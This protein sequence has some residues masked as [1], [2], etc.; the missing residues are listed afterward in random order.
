MELDEIAGAPLAFDFG[1][2]TGDVNGIGLA[3]DG[4]LGSDLGID[5]GTDLGGRGLV[6]GPFG[7]AEVKGEGG[8]AGGAEME[9]YGFGLGVAGFLLE[10]EAGGLGGPFESGGEVEVDPD[11]RVST[12]GAVAGGT[13]E[14]GVDAVVGGE[15]GEGSGAA[16]PAVDGVDAAGGVAVIGVVEGVAVALHGSRAE[17]GVEHD[18]LHAVAVVAVAGG[19][20]EITGY[21]HVGIG[22]AGGLEGV[23]GLGEAG[24]DAVGAGLFEGLLGGP[25]AG[26]VALGLEHAEAV[27]GGLKV[28]VAAADE[29][30]LHG[31]AEGVDVAVGV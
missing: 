6:L 1:E 26:G 24:E 10:L 18:A 9:P 22:A 17:G 8:G 16:G 5:L 2:A 19:L 14:V 21:F 27:D 12:D 31:G 4:D 3:V 7:D 23:V 29:V 15:L 13:E 25:A 30:R 28:A 11:G 20:E